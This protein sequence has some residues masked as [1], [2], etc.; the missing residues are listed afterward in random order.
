MCVPGV[1]TTCISCMQGRC[2][3]SFLPGAVAAR[4]KGHCFYPF[5]VNTRRA[6]HRQSHTTFVFSEPSLKRGYSFQQNTRV[7]PAGLGWGKTPVPLFLLSVFFDSRFESKRTFGSSLALLRSNKSSALRLS[8]ERKQPRRKRFRRTPQY[9]G[10]W[11]FWGGLRE[12]PRS[13]ARHLFCIFSFFPFPLCRRFDSPCTCTH[14]SGT[15]P[16]I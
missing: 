14:M 7:H 16:G 12:T 6:L 15:D 4:S 10:L 2:R 11:H 9:D 13:L 8:S 5:E 1:T 3:E